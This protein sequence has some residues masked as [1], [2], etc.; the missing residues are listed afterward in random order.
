MKVRIHENDSNGEPMVSTGTVL[1]G[2]NALAVVAEIQRQSPFTY[3]LEPL[4]Y[5]RDVLGHTGA[6]TQTLPD[7][8]EAA[9]KEFLLRLA[10]RDIIRFE[11][12]NP[13]PPCLMETIL[14]I[15]DSG[16]TNMLDIPVVVQLAIESGEAEVANWINTHHRDY[17]EII[18]HGRPN[19]QPTEVK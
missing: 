10:K 15:R 19:S 16:K 6:E 4:P 17:A 8:P 3:D 11:E 7:D 13:Y 12:E 2:E 18:F 1:S 9:A 14:A 5:M